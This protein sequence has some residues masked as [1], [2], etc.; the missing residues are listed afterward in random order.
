MPRD[1]TRA[2]PSFWTKEANRR[3]A[4]TVW[5]RDD[6]FHPTAGSRRPSGGCPYIRTGRGVRYAGACAKAGC[7]CGEA[8]LQLV[9]ACNC[10][11]GRGVWLGRTQSRSGR[12]RRCPRFWSAR[13]RRSCWRTYFRV[14]IY[15]RGCRGYGNGWLRGEE[16][17]WRCLTW[18]WSR[19]K[20]C[21]SR[22]C[23]GSLGRASE[24]A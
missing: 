20:A 4:R 7:G 16:S 11:G 1:P 24:R 8:V 3:L 6:L 21:C 13:V 17:R 5:R 15:S 9:V 19:P 18:R 22:G 10:C 23:M 14:A 12:G 2:V